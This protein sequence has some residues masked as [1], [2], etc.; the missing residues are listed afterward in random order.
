MDTFNLSG[1]CALITGAAGLL[2]Y[3]HASALL[4]VG[5]RVVITDINQQALS[6]TYLQLKKEFPRSIVIKQAM[7][8]TCKKSIEMAKNNLI[9]KHEYQIFV[10]NLL[11][12]LSG[13]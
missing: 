9:D 5:S 3:E 6:I 10:Y 13:F 11:L 8:V 4:E 12:P 1:N 2:G 7:D